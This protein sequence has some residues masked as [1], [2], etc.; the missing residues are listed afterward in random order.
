MSLEPFPEQMCR[1]C[2][3]RSRLITEQLG[4]CVNCI[5]NRSQEALALTDAAHAEQAEAA[6]REAGLHTVRVGNRHLLSRD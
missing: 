2:G 5:R 3:V 6:A 4:V 1:L